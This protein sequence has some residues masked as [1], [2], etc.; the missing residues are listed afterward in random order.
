M[1]GCPK[2]SRHKIVAGGAGSGWRGGRDGPP[3]MSFNQQTA[4]R[5]GSGFPIVHLV[6]M[7]NM[8]SR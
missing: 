6:N 5:P 1:G 8:F 3:G 2:P 4:Y 7:F